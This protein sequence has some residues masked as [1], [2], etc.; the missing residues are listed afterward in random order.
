[1]LLLC[2][3]SSASSLFFAFRFHNNGISIQ[4]PIVDLISP[5]VFL[6]VFFNVLLFFVAI[7]NDEC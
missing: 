5:T 7:V 6:F 3:L 4:W 2:F 1:M